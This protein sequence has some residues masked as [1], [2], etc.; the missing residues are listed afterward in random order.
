MTS[1]KATDR[2]LATDEPGLGQEPPPFH[3]R[4]LMHHTWSSLSFLHW[5]YDPEILQRLLPPGLVAD[6]HDG[7]GYVGLIWGEMLVKCKPSGPA[8]ARLWTG[9]GL[10][11]SLMCRRS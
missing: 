10:G 1:N 6:T 8:Q 5:P 7:S 4:P 11:R 3:E 9:R 2:E